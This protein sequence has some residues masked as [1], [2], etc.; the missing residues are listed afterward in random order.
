MQSNGKV[1]SF[2]FSH[3][4]RSKIY[5]RRV[6]VSKR[7]L[8][9]GLLSLVLV[10][11]ITVFSFAIFGVFNSGLTSEQNIAAAFINPAVNPL[12]SAVHAEQ[13]P[14][15]YSRPPVAANYVPNS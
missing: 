6:E 14:I 3:S 12:P 7:V 1:F 2:L 4:F 11:G 8:Q 10:F 15:D 5:I 9:N 13:N